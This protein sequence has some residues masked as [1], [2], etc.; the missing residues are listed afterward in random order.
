MNIKK[1]CMNYD[2]FA[3]SIKG[4]LNAAAAGAFLLCNKLI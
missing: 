3:K 1:L 2:D 4:R